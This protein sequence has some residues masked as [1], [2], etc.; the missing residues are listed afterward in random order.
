MHAGQNVEEVTPGHLA[1]LPEL[2]LDLHILAE[3]EYLS[4]EIDE[5]ILRHMITQCM[6]EF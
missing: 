4:P 5:V 2:V 1:L 3:F 6:E